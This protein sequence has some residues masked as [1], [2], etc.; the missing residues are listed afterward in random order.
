MRATAGGPM[1][2]HQHSSAFDQ[3]S[4]ST[5][6][7]AASAAV[8]A[9]AA[10]G[11]AVAQTLQ[12]ATTLEDV[13]VTASGHE[14]AV[15]Q[16]PATIT[17][18]EGDDLNRRPYASVVDALRDVPGVVVSTGASF[19]RSGAQ[20]ISI[21]GLGESY[22]LVLVNGRPIGNSGEATYDGFG[23]GLSGSYLPPPSAIARIEVI[24]GPM[25]SLYGSSALGGVINIITRPVAEA[26]T[27][28]V[29]A[30][31]TAF[32]HDEDGRS[33]EG[34][35][36][37]SGP[38]VHER[39]GLSVSGALHD[40]SNHLLTDG[41]VQD[42]RR[43]SLGA[44][45]DWA[46]AGD[47]NAALEVSREHHVTDSTGVGGG[48]DVVHMNYGL[49]HDV[50]WGGGYQTNSFFN[51]EDA[52][53]TRYPNP[54][55][56]APN[57]APSDSG[58]S[59]LNLNSRTRAVIGRHDVTIGG[60]YRWEETRHTPSR[61][62]A[63]I[64]P[65]MTR[66][67]AALFGEDSWRLSEDFTATLGFRYDE[68]ERYGS[69]F[70]P[71]LYGVWNVSPT[72]VFRGGVSGGYKVPQLKQAD[73]D[74]IETAARGRGWDQGNSDLRP[75]ES[76]NYEVGLIWQGFGG[77][78]V[79]VTVYRTEFT[80][81]IDRENIC[82]DPVGRTCL[83][84]EYIAQYVNR[85]EA[86][87]NGAELTVDV[88]IQAVDVSFNYTYADSEITRGVNAGAR[89]NS[90]PEHVANLR[91][92]WQARDTLTFW[93]KTQYRSATFDAGN[94]LVP[95]HVIHDLGVSYDVSPTLQANLGVN[96]L[97]DERFSNDYADGRRLYLLFT[98]RF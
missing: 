7:W 88:P 91:L 78:Q 62:P 14:Q 63:D 96:N 51:F 31:T 95:D 74:I 11:L 59:Q 97:T 92:D 8:L 86:E 49:S 56:T 37:F 98:A 73:S 76:L 65:T 93:S 44:K 16:A 94:Q 4:L 67:H 18:I 69:H 60:D 32:E 58:Y 55:P 43:E 57:P 54:L 12:A 61:V 42:V 77:A 17:I 5:A 38:L 82:S 75:E 83:G 2:T 15:R 87:L 34:R 24:R 13:V 30:G 52:E 9:L 39:V 90:L 66:W 81:K 85:D 25:S 29:A 80:D 89:F 84:R 27:G 28:S 64:D 79:G 21:R 19:G 70:T 68:N 10:P 1:Q 50:R 6:A 48:I 26:W 72:L 71:R 33:Y 20:T 41:S 3:R 22:V 53:F 35:F 47:Q 40:R 46:I 36:S 23:A 45:L